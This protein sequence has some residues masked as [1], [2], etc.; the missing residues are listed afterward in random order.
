[1]KEA[2]WIIRFCQ[3]ISFESSRNKGRSKDYCREEEKILR[4]KLRYCMKKVPIMSGNSSGNQQ[5]R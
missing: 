1:M 2:L 5:K 3:W 4:W